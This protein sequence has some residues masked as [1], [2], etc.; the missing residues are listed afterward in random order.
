MPMLWAFPT[1]FIILVVESD[2]GLTHLVS[3]CKPHTYLSFQK[4]WDANVM[5]GHR[6]CSSLRAVG[7]LDV[8]GKGNMDLLHTSIS[9]IH[10]T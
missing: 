3:N 4:L 9:F 10:P 5:K 7:W 8:L 6:E 2:R 1:P